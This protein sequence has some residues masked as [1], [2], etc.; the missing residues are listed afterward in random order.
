MSSG[1]PSFCHIVLD[2]IHVDAPSSMIH[3]WTSDVPYFDWY[4]YSNCGEKMW[5]A[6]IKV[7]GDESSIGRV[8]CA[9]SGK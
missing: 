3:R 4:L 2:M 9:Q 1:K 8:N 5:F 7:K 6:A